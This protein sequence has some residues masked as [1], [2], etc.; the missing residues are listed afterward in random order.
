MATKSGPPSY[1]QIHSNIQGK[2]RINPK[3]MQ[4]SVP[5]LTFSPSVG[6][7]ARDIEKL[8]LDIRS[9]REPLKRA[10]QRVIIPSI[11]E[12]FNQEGRPGW[13]PYSPSTLEIRERLGQPVGKLLN[14]TGALQRV[15]R[16]FNI[17]TVN[18]NAAILLDLPSSV[19]YGKIHQGGYSKGS[20]AAAVKKS[21]NAA[22][23]FKD[24]NNRIKAAMKSGT[25]IKD[26]NFSIPARPF[27]MLQEQ[28]IPAIQKVF[29]DWLKERVDA[30]WGKITR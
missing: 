4:A 11:Q 9:F 25:T 24:M 23:A 18:N 12:N 15:M 28:D 21:G 6:I 2:L 26:F 7:I 30:H 5:Q 22:Q 16:Q 17:W 3:V 1:Q 14:K 10:V 29:E 8:G 19:S 13:E 20:M 27:V